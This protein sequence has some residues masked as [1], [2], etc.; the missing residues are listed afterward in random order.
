MTEI[1][2]ESI[3]PPERSGMAQVASLSW[4]ASLTMLNT[5]IVKFVDG[6]MVSHVGHTAF[7]A[8]YAASMLAFGPEALALGLLMV[9]NTFVS[10]NFGAGRGRRAGLYAWACLA[11]AVGFATIM[12]PMFFLAGPIFDT[13]NHA[14]V[15]RGMELVYFR[16]MVIAAF[17]TLPARV[18]EQFFFGI[19]RSGIVLAVSLL[20]NAVNILMNYVLIFGKLG[21]PAMGLEGAAIGSLSA[22][23]VQ[24]AVLAVLFLRRPMRRRFG[25]HMIRRF[26][27]SRC[28]ELIRVGW[29]AGVQLC[30]EILCWALFA[31]FL[32]GTYFGSEHLA[33]TTVAMRYVGLSFM[34]AVGIGLATTAIVGKC[35]G[36]GRPDLARRRAHKALMIALIYMGACG[37]VFWLFRY[38]MV[39][40]LLANTP[41]GT[42]AEDANAVIEIAARIMLC[43]AAFQLFDA[44]GI[45]YVGALRGAGDT[46]WPMITTVVASWSITV[47]GGLMMVHLL[48]QLTS[49]GPWIAV[50]AYVVVLGL[51][52]A[53]RFESGVWRKID[54]L[55]PRKRDARAA[56]VGRGIQGEKL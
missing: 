31:T 28:R 11:V 26:R 18:F 12:L 20:A 53:W 24:L 16:Y 22:W 46:H 15:L 43:A 7:G 1:I 23:T 40:F 17:V 4:P 49:V 21:M 56:G 8:Q 45:V 2:P 36:Q 39:R 47:G 13:L 48:P 5:T 37:L 9:V 41:S 44:V 52:M 42:G 55:G 6:Y 32:V 10:Q 38:P 34:P 27:W 35:I 30:S 33:A 14:P 54:L 19:H 3:T 50:S 51:C 29:P 25:T